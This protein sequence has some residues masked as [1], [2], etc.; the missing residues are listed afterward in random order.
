MSSLYDAVGWHEQELQ[1]HQRHLDPG[2]AHRAAGEG[3]ALHGRP[4]RRAPGEVRRPQP[5]DRRGAAG[6]AHGAEDRSRES[7]STEGYLRVTLCAIGIILAPIGYQN[8][9]TRFP[10]ILHPS[11]PA[12]SSIG[13]TN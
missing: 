1:A 4:T 11:L 13:A 12:L 10:R 5:G 6:G 9:V 7:G 8:L 3:P 2:A